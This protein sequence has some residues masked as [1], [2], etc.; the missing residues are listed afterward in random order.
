MYIYFI[1]V[2]D[3][4]RERKLEFRVS[5]PGAFEAVIQKMMLRGAEEETMSGGVELGGGG[6]RMERVLLS[7][8]HLRFADKEEI[9][10]ALK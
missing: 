4:H 8:R 2:L 9:T 3:G 1:S 6:K 7:S 5:F 10:F